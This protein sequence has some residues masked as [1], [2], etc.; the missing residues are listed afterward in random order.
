[1]GEARISQ[2]KRDELKEIEHI[3]TIRTAALDRAQEYVVRSGSTHWSIPQLVA[4]AQE[5]EWYL[6]TGMEWSERE[7]MMSERTIKSQEEMLH[8]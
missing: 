1:M 8:E 3:L 4:A 7:K 6:A 2:M 5:L